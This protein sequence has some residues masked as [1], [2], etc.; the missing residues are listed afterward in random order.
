[1]R[2]PTDGSTSSA[3]FFTRRS[4]MAHTD[5][6]AAASSEKDREMSGGR[7]ED[8]INEAEL[9]DARSDEGSDL[10]ALTANTRDDD[11][12][13]P[14]ALAATPAT[15]A[16]EEPTLPMEEAMVEAQEHAEQEESDDVD[17][18]GGLTV[19]RRQPVKARQEYQ[20]QASREFEEKRKEL[21]CERCNTQGNIRPNGTG[22]GRLMYKCHGR[23]EHNGRGNCGKTFTESQIMLLLNLELKRRGD[24]LYVGPKT[25]RRARPATASVAIPTTRT[26]T[27]PVTQRAAQNRQAAG[28][29]SS[30]PRSSDPRTELQLAWARVSIEKLKR[31]V[32]DMARERATQSRQIHQLEQ[33]CEQMCVENDQLRQRNDQLEQRYEQMRQEND[34]MRQRLDSLAPRRATGEGETPT[35]PQ[36]IARSTRESRDEWAAW[37]DDGPLGDTPGL[38]IAWTPVTNRGWE[39]VPWARREREENLGSSRCERWR[40]RL[41][42]I[43]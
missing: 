2:E 39:A 14:T 4:R 34:Q 1:M 40:E 35:S 13:D 10:A 9:Q 36:P 25:D 33:R 12:E 26:A 21:E 24:K 18:N 37:S 11:E 29:H 5:A 22:N 43:G 17:T 28:A 32:T 42:C 3:N 23:Y 27:R 7:E 8:R 38:G 20:V 31:E 15:N 19:R 16:D 6:E 41:G 30:Q